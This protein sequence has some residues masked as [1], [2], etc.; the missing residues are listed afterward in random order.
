VDGDFRARHDVWRVFGA[1]ADA[2]RCER[3][4]FHDLAHDS[5]NG[6]GHDVFIADGASTESVAQRFPD[7]LGG[8]RLNLVWIE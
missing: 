5:A 8:T 1:E 6:H 4:G 7:G 2:P 3:V